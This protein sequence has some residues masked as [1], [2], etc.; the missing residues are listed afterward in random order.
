MIT[1]EQP[2]TAI[3]KRKLDIWER[4]G[5]SPTPEQ[6]A[7]HMDE[8]RLRLVA[9]GAQAGK[10]YSAAMEMAGRFQGDGGDGLFW[11]V[12]EEYADTKREFQY[13]V[14]A[15]TR[16]GLSVFSSKN[17]NPGE[18]VIS[19]DIRFETKSAND[20]RKLGAVAPRGILGCEAA[21]FSVTTYHR[22]RE[23][24]APKRG[25]LL[26]SGTFEGSM[27]WYPEL[28]TKW[29]VENPEG[30]RSFSIPTWSNK[31]L[32]PGGR[33]DPEILLLEASTPPDIFQER[34]GAVPCPPSGR[35]FPEF[36][37][38]LHIKS[39]PDAEYPWPIETVWCDSAKKFITFD[40]RAPVYLWTDPGY[41]GACSVL[42]AQIPGD[43]VYIFDEIYLQGVVTE[44]IIHTAQSR[45]WWKLRDV[46][47][48]DYHYIHQ[49]QAMPAVAEVWQKKA[50]VHLRS[51]RVGINE[52]NERLKTFLLPDRV[53]GRP[54]VY[55]DP[56]CQG[57][58]SEL[59]GA[60]NPF[61]GQAEVYRWKV[62]RSGAVIGKTPEDKNNHSIKALIYGLVDKFGYATRTGRRSGGYN[63]L[64][65]RGM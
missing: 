9:G 21:Q 53:S 14:D 57:L 49:H 62:D 12:G 34:F 10:S 56:A 43:T 63:Y 32:Y 45:P 44:D 40:P 61:S 33:D 6:M 17:V 64:T 35:V 41:A 4:L 19:G 16:L 38:F 2:L 58:I 26:L 51:Q 31:V 7:M 36:Q 30:G 27:G 8:H 11:L 42:A 28:W 60:P 37:M 29:Q 24:I 13:L 48:G 52:G 20:E 65:G 54:H 3:Q 50:G 59:G 22:L 15:F 46:H 1:V 47:V 23:R 55:I 39:M 18:I 25:W 5:Y